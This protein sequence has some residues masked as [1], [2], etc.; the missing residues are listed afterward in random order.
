MYNQKPTRRFSTQRPFED[1]EGFSKRAVPSSLFRLLPR[2]DNI[3]EDGEGHINT[4]DTGTTKL[5]KRLAHSSHTPWRHKYFGQFSTLKGFWYYIKSDNRDDRFR[6]LTGPRLESLKR[7]FEGMDQFTVE[8]P[9]FRA[10]ILDATYQKIQQF[11]D[12][13]ALMRESDLP[14]DCYFYNRSQDGEQGARIR[15][16]FAV[17]LLDGLEEIRNAL[18]EDRE[19]DFTKYYDPEH[20]DLDL[21]TGKAKKVKPPVVREEAALTTQPV[22]K[23]DEGVEIAATDEAEQEQTNDQNNKIDDLLEMLKPEEKLQSQA[24]EDNA[25]DVLFGDPNEAP[26]GIAS[27]GVVVDLLFPEENPTETTSDDGEQYADTILLP[28]IIKNPI[29]TVQPKPTNDDESGKEVLL[30][31]KNSKDALILNQPAEEQEEILPGFR[32]LREAENPEDEE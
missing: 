13:E 31:N 14:F 3:G 22:E 25:V 15:L 21:Y 2:A 12:T 6:T 24:F 16:K 26:T 8:V 11:S 17:W 23:G 19:P 9:N 20:L 29:P 5:G 18:K 28:E 32:S 4:W 27:D 7:E 10:L 1:L 30:N